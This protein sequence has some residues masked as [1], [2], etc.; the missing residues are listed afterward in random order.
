MRELCHRWDTSAS[1]CLKEA[2]PE[3]LLLLPGN[4]KTPY[5]AATLENLFWQ[6]WLGAQGKEQNFRFL[7]KVLSPRATQAPRT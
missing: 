1:G 4:S 7:Q 3:A 6:K 5:S 2:K